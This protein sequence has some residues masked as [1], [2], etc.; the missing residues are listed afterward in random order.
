MNPDHA[1]AAVLHFRREFRTVILATA[2]PDGEPAA[3]PAAAVL[4][5]DGAF[6]LH[7]SG[8]AVHTRHLLANPRASVLLIEDEAAA[9]QPLARRRLTFAC[10][11]RR[12]DRESPE[13]TRRL[14]QLREKFGPIFDTL[15]ALPDFVL[16]ALVPERGRLVIGFGAAFDV[17]PADW[18]NLTHVGPPAR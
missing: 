2:S 15:A 6:Y 4:G 10:R 8:L 16:L 11:V 18:T 1:R 17:D 9:G 12:V 13:H 3:S 7:V 5:E 14:G